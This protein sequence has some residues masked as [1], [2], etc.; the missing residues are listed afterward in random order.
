MDYI[1]T[2][3]TGRRA[4]LS[5]AVMSGLAPDGGFYMP[6]SVPRLPRAFFNN[7]S[8][9]TLDEIAYVVANSLFGTDVP[10]DT[11][12]HI[13]NEAINFDIPLHRLADGYSVL[14][15][16]HGPTLSY[17]DVGTRFMARLLPALHNDYSQIPNPKSRVKVLVATHGDTGGAVADGCSSIPGVEVY[18]IFP[19]GR[20]SR[21]QLAQLTAPGGNIHPVAVNCSIQECRAMVRQAF[22]DEELREH[23]TLVSANTINVARLLPQTIYFFQAYA[24]LT[25]A[26]RAADQVVIGIPA[27]NLGN[28][29]AAVLAKQMGLPVKRFIIANSHPDDLSRL[30]GSGAAPS[31][32]ADFNNTSNLRRLL[33]LYDGSVE[34]LAADVQACIVPHEESD[35]TLCD[36]LQRTGYLIDPHGAATLHAVK[37]M[38]HT[39]ET[40]I[41]L[42]PAHPAK[43]AELLQSITGVPV[44][45]PRQYMQ[46]LRTHHRPDRIAPNY[47]ALRNYLI[48]N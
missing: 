5:E 9:L 8:D 13:V 20:M 40:A 18:V 46:T 45:I 34:R 28:L 43:H 3:G 48:S 39:G 7:I 35:V 16:F 14:E 11:L 21:L 42:A 6:S 29:T 36:V 22:L 33:S 10:A 26:E 44:E 30:L 19:R 32:P 2:S 12:Q 15:L 38:R 17:K 41:V 23:C 25:D 24:R 1:S 4:T 27:G 37:Q 47:D 31:R